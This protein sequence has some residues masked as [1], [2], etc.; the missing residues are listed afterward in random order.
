MILTNIKAL[1][2]RNIFGNSAF[3]PIYNRNDE[4]VQAAIKALNK[5]KAAFPIANDKK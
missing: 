1:I 2:A 4:T 3:Y 5:H